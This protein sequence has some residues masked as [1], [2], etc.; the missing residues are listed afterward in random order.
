MENW[1]VVELRKYARRMGIK[2]S[3][4]K[5]ELIERIVAAELSQHRQAA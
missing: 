1:T 4:N 2:V 5:A 3:G